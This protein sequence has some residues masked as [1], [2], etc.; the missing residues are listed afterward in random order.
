MA[1]DYSI[2]G[3]LATTT[4]NNRIRFKLNQ[5]IYDYRLPNEQVKI[6]ALKFSPDGTHL[7]IISRTRNTS[8]ELRIS[9]IKQTQ[10]RAD[11]WDL[12]YDH[13]LDQ[14]NI[15]SFTFLNH[16]RRSFVEPSTNNNE[17]EG[18]IEISST[19]YHVDNKKEVIHS[20]IGLPPCS[21]S[22]NPSSEDEDH[23]SIPHLLIATQTK[24]K[25]SQ[26]PLPTIKQTI[27]K[28]IL[29]ST[30]NQ[31][32]EDL[33]DDDQD[34]FITGISD[35]DQAFD[36]PKS[37]S[38]L[39]PIDDNED[40][41]GLK[42]SSKPS[43]IHQNSDLVN[44]QYIKFEPSFDN[45]F[46]LQKINPGYGVINLIEILIDFETHV[47]PNLTINLLPNLSINDSFNYDTESQV[48]L[49]QLSFS[50]IPVNLTSSS[51]R[52]LA[53]FTRDYQQ[54]EEE[55]EEI[56][57]W[58]I[59]FQS[60]KLS[61]G[62]LGLESLITPNLIS[63]NDILRGPYEWV[64]NRIS[65]RKLG[66][67]EDPNM[68]IK[69]RK[70]IP[71]WKVKSGCILLF[72]EKIK[73][74]KKK[75]RKDKYSNW[76][77]NEDQSKREE[78]FGYEC[79]I[80]HGLDLSTID[81]INLD[82]LKSIEIVQICL[83]Y[84]GVYC[85]SIDVNGI[86][87][88]SP[89]V[90]PNQSAT[91]VGLIVN[92]IHNR[93]LVEDISRLLSS[94][95]SSCLTTT[96]TVGEE[97][98]L[99]YMSIFKDVG[100]FIG[101]LSPSN[102]N[103]EYDPN[104]ATSWNL[105][106]DLW[107]SIPGYQRAADIALICLCSLHDHF[108]GWEKTDSLCLIGSVWHMIG[109]S[110]WYS[111][112]CQRIVGS[113][114]PDSETPHLSLLPMSGC[115]FYCCFKIMVA[116][117]NFSNWLKAANPHQQP[118]PSQPTHAFSS[119][120]PA[121]DTFY[122][123]QP[124]TSFAV[125]D[126]DQVEIA[127]TVFAEVWNHQNHIHM[128][129]WGK[130]L[131]DLGRTVYP[132]PGI[133]VTPLPPRQGQGF[134]LPLSA[135]DPVQVRESL[136]DLRECIARHPML[137]KPARPSTSSERPSSS[138]SP[139]ADVQPPPST[140]APRTP[141]MGPSTTP[142]TSPPSVPP[143][144]T[145]GEELVTNDKSTEEG[146]LFDKKTLATLKTI[147]RTIKAVDDRAKYDV[148]VGI[149]LSEILDSDKTNPTLDSHTSKRTLDGNNKIN[150]VSS[151]HQLIQRMRENVEL[152]LY[153]DLGLITTSILLI[154]PSILITLLRFIPVIIRFLTLIVIGWLSSI[155]LSESSR[156]DVLLWS[157][158]Q[159]FFLLLYFF[160]IFLL[161]LILFMSQILPYGLC[162]PS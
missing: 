39:K 50:I 140:L 80:L 63:S 98:Q 11:H 75:C 108:L 18:E 79:W 159:T 10:S 17:E 74:K 94:S 88:A 105:G 158:G 100:T 99:E 61:N 96:G 130:L 137:I 3:I 72:I 153:L 160:L 35:L 95:S 40:D 66:N 41:D 85:Y 26:S 92:G 32:C 84:H 90:S 42:Q 89:L 27:I 110:R 59:K 111:R 136:Q 124:G 33:D 107:S 69:I 161:P 8:N 87:R 93:E 127:K 64:F 150:S 144:T 135:V 44:H 142:T 113:I 51:L 145:G 34:L 56:Q 106:F 21:V 114:D 109:L 6:R 43:I 119:L 122:Q 13:L 77:Q 154:H 62:F 46:N 45:Q 121:T 91:I 147:N 20:A 14:R 38:I 2:Q 4:R 97:D 148:L 132:K 30:S 73:K 65:N 60:S 103:F 29:K 157:L 23:E 120:N 31:P 22:I 123:Q 156:I 128:E 25:P 24:L 141:P 1:I 19:R 16:A 162:T 138:S 71:E 52:L 78:S 7:L 70:I 112:L 86:A 36:M 68:K 152:D 134:I 37:Q 57:A 58:D 117:T 143:R 151:N 54:E 146:T 139:S 82:N 5:A 155:S 131:Q 126:D 49:N 125:R 48:T 115:P 81:I 116:L 15:S 9:I 102:Q 67:D 129:S 47:I 53:S 28:P 104:L 101:L 149:N 83:S 118:R 12:I 55:E 76:I 133:G